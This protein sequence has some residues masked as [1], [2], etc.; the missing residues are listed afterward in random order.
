MANFEFLR[1]E[2]SQKSQNVIELWFTD[3]L[4]YRNFGDNGEV[5]V[6]DVSGN[7]DNYDKEW[8]LER[9][10][11]VVGTTGPKAYLRYNGIDLKGL[12]FTI[13][14][15]VQKR[16]SKETISGTTVAEIN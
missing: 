1:S 16:Y 8:Y 12:T 10:N 15:K 4:E 14:Y 2:R 6:T 7:F 13:D 11:Y 5:V 3:N 9:K